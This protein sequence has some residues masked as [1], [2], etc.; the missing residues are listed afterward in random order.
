MF[1]GTNQTAKHKNS[2][3]PQW[4]WDFQGLAELLKT[5]RVERVTPTIFKASGRRRKRLSFEFFFVITTN[6][7][8]L[9]CLKDLATTGFPLPPL[10]NSEKP[11]CKTMLSWIDV[12]HGIKYY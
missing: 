7:E 4:V 9:M 3:S 1:Q 11:S 8:R 6:Y 10:F 5:E 12:E 2:P